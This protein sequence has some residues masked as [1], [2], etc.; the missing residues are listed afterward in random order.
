MENQNR[1]W[2]VALIAVAII[3]FLGWIIPLPTAPVVSQDQTDQ[4]QAFG[5]SGTRF[6][7]GISAD[8]T[9]PTSG[10]VRGATFTATGASSFGGTVTVTTSNTAT[11]TLIVGCIQTYATS[12]LTPIII[13]ATTTGAPM[14]ARFGSCPV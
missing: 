11:S 5:G 2:W 4:G 7:N 3:A 1:A 13:S 8:A 10:Q 12:T 14:I 9:S 6:P